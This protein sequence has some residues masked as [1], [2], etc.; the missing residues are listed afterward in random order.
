MAEM[1]LVLFLLIFIALGVI[2]LA[3]AFHAT[4]V[5]SG[6]AR[7]GARYGS[8]HPNCLATAVGTC[9]TTAR[10]A[11][12]DEAQS[13]GVILTGDKVSFPGPPLNTNSKVTV[14]V[15]YAYRSIFA[16]FFFSGNPITVTRQ[17]SFPVMVTR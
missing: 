10:Q 6:A 8:E 3:R 12:V 15:Q 1:A 11:A 5:A 9:N 14:R 16:N 17:A 4:V 2:D 7:A 13:Y